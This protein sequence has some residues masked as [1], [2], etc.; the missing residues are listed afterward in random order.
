M[1]LLKID[2]FTIERWLTIFSDLKDSETF[3]DFTM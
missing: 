2:V 1:L 3:L